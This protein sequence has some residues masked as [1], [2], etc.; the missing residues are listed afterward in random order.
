MNAATTNARK[1]PWV[2]APSAP[3]RLLPYQIK[4]TTATPPRNSISGGSTETALVTFRFVRIQ[5]LRG[6][7][8]P[9]ASCASAPNALTIR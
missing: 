5:P 4:P 6:G 9:R 7:L 2:I 3:M 1:S 8:E